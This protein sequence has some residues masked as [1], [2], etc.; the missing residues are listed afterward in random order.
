MQHAGSLV[1]ECELLIA[2]C[3]IKFLD[4]GS[5]LGPLHWERRVLVTGSPGKSHKGFKYSS[6]GPREKYVPFS[7]SCRMNTY[8]ISLNPTNGSEPSPAKH[9]GWHRVT[10]QSL[11]YT[12]HAAVDL[13]LVI[14]RLF[15]EA[16]EV[17]G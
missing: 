6:D 2:A 16:A 11:L 9:V 12:R 14:R 5:N 4:Q 10:H 15:A 3:G 8:R 13:S 17:C 7:L 1:E